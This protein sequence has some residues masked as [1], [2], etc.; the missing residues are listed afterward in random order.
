MGKKTGANEMNI[1]YSKLAEYRRCGR[2]YFF[3]RLDPDAPPFVTKAH[4]HDGSAY[5]KGV[6]VGLK[7]KQETGAEPNETAMTDAFVEYYQN[8]DREIDFT[9]VDKARAETIGVELVKIYRSGAIP[10][11]WPENVEQKFNV[12]FSNRDWRLVVVPDLEARANGSDMIGDGPARWSD[13]DGLLVDHKRSAKAPARDAAEHDEQLTAYAMSK[14]AQDG[15]LP[16]IVRLDFALAWKTAP[17]KATADR[18]AAVKE[19]KHGAVGILP[20]AAKRTQ[21]DVDHYL[22]VMDATIA[23]MRDGV[24]NYAAPQAWWCSPTA[25]DF[26]DYCRSKGPRLV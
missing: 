20:L 24:Y 3:N 8:P 17:K 18:L 16:D 12:D 4:M 19:T 5:H 11:L 1:S 21:A 13:K 10:Y 7:E 26:W 25:C 2:H 14:W 22:N 23:N 9:D 6:A 15:T